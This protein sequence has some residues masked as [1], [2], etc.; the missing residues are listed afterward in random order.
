[1]SLFSLWLIPEPERE[2]TLTALIAKLARDFQCLPFT[3]HATV[4]TGIFGS[5]E[6][7]VAAT[8]TL[9]EA[10]AP[11]AAAVE[12]IAS[13]DYYYRFLYYALTKSPALDA[14]NERACK[15]FNLAPLEYHPHISLIY[16]DPAALGASVVASG[17]I[18]QVRG[19][20]I[21]FDRLVLMETTGGE[22]EWVKVAE[23]PLRGT[24]R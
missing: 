4:V 3:P 22:G 14:L 10:T 8:A 6:E 12:G 15:A 19:D 13:E 1:M 16:A 5:A 2:K 24:S 21:R 7:T 11:P 9:A 20:V 18:P 23:F 17:V